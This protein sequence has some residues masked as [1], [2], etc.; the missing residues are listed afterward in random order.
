MDLVLKRSWVGLLFFFFSSVGMVHSEI[1]E[2][3]TTNEIFQ[4]EA[5]ILMVQNFI[6]DGNVM[7]DM[8]E[9][10]MDTWDNARTI[11]GVGEMEMKEFHLPEICTELIPPNEI[12]T[13]IITNLIVAEKSF[14]DEPM[15]ITLESIM[16]IKIKMSKLPTEYIG[17]EE[18]RCEEPSSCEGNLSGSSLSKIVGK[19]VNTTLADF[20]PGKEKKRQSL[21]VESRGIGLESLRSNRRPQPRLP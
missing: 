10:A 2:T 13:S 20:T 6:T 18:I 19:V 8:V 4:P 17:T 9:K 12:Q 5:L 14:I 3:C 15:E 16:N 11:N 1:E 21:E 7:E